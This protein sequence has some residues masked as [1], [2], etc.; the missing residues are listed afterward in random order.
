MCGVSHRGEEASQAWDGHNGR[1]RSGS[2]R[3]MNRRVVLILAAVLMGACGTEAPPYSPADL[4]RALAGDR[5]LSGANLSGA[6]LSGANLTSANLSGANL[7]G[8][9]LIG[10][11][12]GG[13]NLIGANLSDANLSDAVLRG[14]NLTDANL[15]GTRLGGVR[16]DATT[17]WPA[18]IT[19]PTCDP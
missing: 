3:G 1:T 14:A 18:N 7:S 9:N 6:N 17:R 8:A 19:R 10:A 4:Q 16:C 15:S 12:L 5:N 13:A 2:V 11:Y